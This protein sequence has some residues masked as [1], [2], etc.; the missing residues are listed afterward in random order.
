MDVRVA[1]CGLPSALEGLILTE[2]LRQIGPRIA[3][4]C[5]EFLQS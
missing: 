3:R 5:E 2:P 1:E 4:G